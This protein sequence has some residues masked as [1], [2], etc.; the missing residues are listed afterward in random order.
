MKANIVA[1]FML[2]NNIH[3]RMMIATLDKMLECDLLNQVNIEFYSSISN[4][5][6]KAN[7]F[8]QIKFQQY[9]GRLFTKS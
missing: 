4:E 3:S 6:Q 7:F 9:E 5:N 1:K 2:M 8:Q